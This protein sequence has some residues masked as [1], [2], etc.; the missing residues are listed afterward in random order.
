MKLEH[1][2]SLSNLIQNYRPEQI[3]LIDRDSMDRA[4]H[5]YNTLLKNPDATDLDAMIE[6]Y[7]KKSSSAFRKLKTRLR[8]K[9]LNTLFF[10]DLRGPKHSTLLKASMSCYRQMALY[11]ILTRFR[12]TD[13]ALEVGRKL[14]RKAEEYDLTE[15]IYPVLASMRMT[16]VTTRLDYKKYRHY[17]K[18]LEEHYD[19]IKKK[20]LFED[21]LCKLYGSYGQTR[22]S[23]KELILDEVE[24]H[25]REIE[26]I[27]KNT[28]SQFLHRRGYSIKILYATIK[29]DADLA[30]DYCNE[31]IH[32]FKTNP[33][34]NQKPPVVNYII[35]KLAIYSRIRKF[36]QGDDIYNKGL[37]LTTSYSHDWHALHYY[38]FL[39]CTQTGNY[40]RAFET[41]QKVNNDPRFR[42]LPTFFLEAWSIFEAYVYIIL[43]TLNQADDIHFSA[44][45]YVN[46]IPTYSNDKRGSNVSILIAHFI[47]LCFQGNFMQAID[48]VDALKQYTHRHLKSDDTKRS[49]CFIRMLISVAKADFNPIRAERY[50]EK[51]HKVLINTPAS[52]SE[53]SN[54]IEIIPYE[55][56]WKILIKELEKK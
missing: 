47:L 53:Q 20:H 48:R 55:E 7:G 31:A 6:I 2:A 11:F 8:D 26:E 1:L 52:I 18:K 15:V 27:Q 13:L 41:Y 5:L 40:K 39:L 37:N 22:A 25:L 24:S 46:N 49:N 35:Q 42:K 23:V 34:Y 45:K 32:F 14:V 12:Q 21:Q 36:K 30:L 38:Y 54:E 9:L 44:N 19:L 43:K 29:G 33:I 10:I 51:Y 56:L 3:H 16:Y 4:N 28:D 50:A 17:D